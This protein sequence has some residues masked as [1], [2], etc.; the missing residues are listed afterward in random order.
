MSRVLLR[1]SWSLLTPGV[2]DDKTAARATDCCGCCPYGL[3]CWSTLLLLLLLL[4]RVLLL[5]RRRTSI[6]IE[7]RE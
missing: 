4:K 6:G 5:V 7:A 1:Q 2:E 3:R